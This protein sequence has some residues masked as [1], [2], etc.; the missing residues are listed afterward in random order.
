M[1]NRKKISVSRISVTKYRPDENTDDARNDIFVVAIE[2]VR[3]DIKTHYVKIQFRQLEAI[4]WKLS[5]NLY[6]NLC[7]LLDKKKCFI[8]HLTLLYHPFIFTKEIT[9]RARDRL[10]D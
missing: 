10:L 1:H 8:K 3:L 5:E 9:S 2:N 4:K 6:G 7:L